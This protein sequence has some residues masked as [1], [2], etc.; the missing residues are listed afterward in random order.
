MYAYTTLDS[1]AIGRSQMPMLTLI[2]YCLRPRD[3]L[4]GV[5]NARIKYD[6]LKIKFVV[7]KNHGKNYAVS[8][9]TVSDDMREGSEFLHAM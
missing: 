5:T 8:A 4:G 2:I 3:I 7:R 1:A 9:E 6:T